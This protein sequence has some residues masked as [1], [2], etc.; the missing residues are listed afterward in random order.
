MVYALEPKTSN[1]SIGTII[2][3]SVPTG[4]LLWAYFNT[5]YWI[6]NNTLHY[7]SAFLKGNIPI[8]KITQLLVSKTMWVGLKPAL[9]SKGIIVKYNKFDEIYIAPVDN[10]ALCSELIKHNPNIKIIN[11]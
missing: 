9:A 5:A 4:L 10:A 7:K 2:L 6:T 3:M 11:A 1:T 8:N